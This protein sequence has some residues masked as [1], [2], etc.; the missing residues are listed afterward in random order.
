VKRLNAKYFKTFLEH[1]DVPAVLVRPGYPRSSR[2]IRS[3]SR[4]GFR[5]DCALKDP[6]SQEACCGSRHG[7]TLKFKILDATKCFEYCQTEEL[8]SRRVLQDIFRKQLKAVF[9]FY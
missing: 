9:I 1:V 4:T 3:R 2:C 5:D 8:F 6:P 7:C